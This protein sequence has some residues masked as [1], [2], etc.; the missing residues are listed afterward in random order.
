MNRGSDGGGR[1]WEVEIYGHTWSTNRAAGI[2]GSIE[3]RGG[4]V[5]QARLPYYITFCTY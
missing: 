2:S 1:H 3:V 4:L 5:M